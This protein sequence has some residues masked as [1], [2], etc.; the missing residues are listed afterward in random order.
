MSVTAVATS[1]GTGTGT[2]YLNTNVT[3]FNTFA[4]AGV[5]SSDTVSYVVEEGTK[6]EYGESIYTVLGSC[7]ALARG[8]TYSSIG[9]VTAESFTNAATV[10]IAALAEDLS[11][12]F[13]M[14]NRQ[15]AV[16][17]YT[18]AT[19]SNSLSV[20]PVSVGTGYTVTIPSCS[21]WLVL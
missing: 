3:G 20:G 21:R 5:L 9:S 18:L 13:M 7:I 19:G 2:I 15:T 17:S 16:F 12:D 14:I 1:T 10:F 6:W 4:N 8:P 11:P